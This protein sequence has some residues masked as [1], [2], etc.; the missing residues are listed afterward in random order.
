[1]KKLFTLFLS[2]LLLIT[3]PCCGAMPGTKN[4]DSAQG[5]SSTLQTDEATQGKSSD[6]DTEAQSGEAARPAYKTPQ[7]ALEASP[8]LVGLT[9]QKNGRLLVRDLAK[10]WSDDSSVI[11]EYKDANT[12]SAAGLK[13]R[14]SEIFGGEV[15]LFC[16]P[17]GAGILSYETK[18]TLF[19]TSRVGSNPHAV[20]LLPDGT[21]IVGSTSDNKVTV[22]DA[23]GGNTEPIQTLSY[24]NVHGALWD[25]KYQVLWMAGRT[26]LSAFSV[27]GTGENARISLI[28]GMIYVTGDWLHDLFP[29]Y[30]NPQ[31]LFVTC[32][33]GI[34]L[35][36][37]EKEKFLSTYP[38]SSLAAKI[39]TAPAA[40]AFADHVMVA[41]PVISGKTVHREW[42]M[43]EISVMVP[44]GKSTVRKITRTAP[45]DAYYKVRVWC[46]DYQ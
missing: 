7:E 13:L 18:E 4:T 19:F 11:W 45:D 36:D 16:G 9:D 35:F 31:A 41:M 40:G 6:P 3:L 24:E 1:M 22:F 28:Q 37:K 42:C 39:T 32:A 5:S 12:A 10:D 43:N 25:P 30:G 21:F 34:F 20:E 2:G 44:M 27:S 33:E 15:V 17:R 38:C 26:K 46:A 8:H 23:A 14:D 29:C